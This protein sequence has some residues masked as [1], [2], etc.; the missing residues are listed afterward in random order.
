M[1]DCKKKAPERG[2]WKVLLLLDAG[3]ELPTWPA[4]SS[5]IV[6]RR[7]SCCVCSL[8]NFRSIAAPATDHPAWLASTTPRPAVSNA[9]LGDRQH[10]TLVLLGREQQA[11]AGT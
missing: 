5:H 10:R 11:T 4:A 1:S 6:L 8:H 7:I 9:A 3:G 2:L